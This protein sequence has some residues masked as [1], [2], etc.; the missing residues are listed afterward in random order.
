[1]LNNN[2]KEFRIEK[3]LTQ[4][5]LAEKIGVTQ[6]AIYFW[7]KGIN[8]PTAGYLIKLAK[9]FGIT[10]DEL[11]SFEYDENK[12]RSGKL[13]KLTNSFCRLNVKQ[14]ELILSIIE[15]LSKN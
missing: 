8:E 14:Q 9:V 4:V 5:Q 10:V 6:G 1:M 15:E 12:T 7:E 3:N 11:L 13:T 2:I